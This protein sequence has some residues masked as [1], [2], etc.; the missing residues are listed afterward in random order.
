MLLVN[1]FCV[2]SFWCICDARAMRAGMYNS[3]AGLGDAQAG[4]ADAQAGLGGAQ[5]GFDA[6]VVFSNMFCEF[7]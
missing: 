3:Q 6:Q 1:E 4:L 7:L 5:A 2:L